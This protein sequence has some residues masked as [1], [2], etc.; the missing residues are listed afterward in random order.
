MGPAPRLAATGFVRCRLFGNGSVHP[1]QADLPE[2]VKL[3]DIEQ[4]LQ[5]KVVSTIADDPKTVDQAINEGKLIRMVNKKSDA[6]R[7]ISALVSLLTDQGD[8]GVPPPQEGEQQGRGFFA[9]LFSR[10]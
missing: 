4:N 7:D 1:E 10:G 5:L 2:F 9:S 6:A 3:Q 8:P